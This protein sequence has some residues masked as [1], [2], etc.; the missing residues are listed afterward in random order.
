MT[1]IPGNT[2]VSLSW[3]APASDGGEA[4]TGYRV[5]VATSSGGTYTNAAGPCA[6]ATGRTAV[7]CAATGLANGTQYFFKVAAINSV[8]T[9]SDS[10][11]SSGVTP[12]AAPSAPTGVTG[13]PG[14]A[15]ASLTWT[16]PTSDGGAAITGYRV[17]VATTGGYTNAAGTCATGTGSTARSC[18][19]TG[20]ANGTQYFFKVAAINSVG[21]GSYSVPSSGVTP[22]ALYSI[23]YDANG[24]TGGTAPV[25]P[26]SP[27]TNGARADVLTNGSLVKTG[28]TF[29]G[30]NTVADGSGF[31]LAANGWFNLS[32]RDYVLYAQWTP[33]AVNNGAC[34]TA[35]NT[36]SAFM[37]SANLCATGST[38]NGS[39]VSGSPW[40][41]TC[42]GSN[43]GTPASCSVATGTTATGTGATR[44][45]VAGGSWVVD[46]VGT[47]GGL[48]NTAG[49]IGTSGNAK[50]PGSVPAGYEFRHG[51]YDFTLTGGNGPATVVLTYPQELP[52][53]TVYWKY[54]KTPSSSTPAWY[55]FTGAVIS[56]D[57]LSIT[58]TLTDGLL[59]D[60]DA[61]T[62]GVIV[63][64]G[65]PAAPAAPVVAATTPVPTLSE[66]GLMLLASLMLMAGLVQVR[67]RR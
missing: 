31:A 24:A 61:T 58:L 32:N 48:P 19:A 5:Q 27:Y 4:I 44:A 21:T 53:G 66:W 34:G 51:L 49:P 35:I 54:G 33:I 2:Q 63:D 11:A 50:S 13:T 16:A 23:T 46:M 42:D 64:P 62:N 6:S 43:G 30:W 26:N 45:V 59:G 29:S 15:Q 65:G 39:V 47:T 7:S 56:S 38:L 37:P 17:L 52:A 9:G 8:G 22:V 57:R 14:N 3:T 10:A 1:S 25:D 12:V 28:Y 41:W 55:Q 18:I 40:T 67:R 36:P 20:L 60:S